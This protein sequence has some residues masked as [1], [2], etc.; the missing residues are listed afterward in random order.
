ML[1]TSGKGRLNWNC[2]IDFFCRILFFTFCV[3]TCLE[4]ANLHSG[5]L[6]SGYIFLYETCNSPLV[7]VG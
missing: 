7:A 4:I 6:I 3:I 1:N 2:F 5:A